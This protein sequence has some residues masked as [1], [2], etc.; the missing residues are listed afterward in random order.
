MRLHRV[1]GAEHA[2]HHLPRQRHRHRRGVRRRSRARARAPRGSSSSAGCTLRTSPPASASSAANTRPV[3]THSIA[4]D[5]PDEPRQEPAT[6]TPRAR[7]RAARTRSR[8]WRPSAARRMSIGSV[9]VM[10]TPTAGPLIAAITGFERVEDAQRHPA[11]A[12]ARHAAPRRRR[13]RASR[14]SRRRRRGRRR[15]RSRGPAPVT[16][17]A[18]TSSSASDAVERLD[19]LA[20]HRRREGVQPVGPVQRDRE[21]RGRRPRSG[22]P[23]SSCAQPK[24]RAQ[25][26]CASHDDHRERHRGGPRARRA[27]DRPERVARGHPG[28][29]RQ[30]R[31]A[32]RRRPVDPRRRR[33]RED[34][35]PVRHDDRPRQPA[36]CR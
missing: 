18:R 21:R 11:A 4:C 10:P 26:G 22:S 6:S 36:R 19:Q 5:D 29:H 9:I 35:E 8:S 31:R 23:G 2:P 28:G 17:T 15:R 30:V 12:V 7:C 20:L 27:D 34:R 24:P 14:T 3:A 32:V 16:I 33:A 13:G 1:V 25:V